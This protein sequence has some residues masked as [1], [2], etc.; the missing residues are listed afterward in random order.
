[1]AWARCTASPRLCA[2]SFR[3]GRDRSE[4]PLRE[5]IGNEQVPSAFNRL[6]PAGPTVSEYSSLATEIPA[7]VVICPSATA[8]SAPNLLARGALEARR[9]LERTG[10]WPY[11]Y[12][13]TRSSWIRE[14]ML[15]LVKTLLR[16][17][18]A[19]RADVEA[20]AALDRGDMAPTAGR[21]ACQRQLHT[22]VVICPRL[23]IGSSEAP[24]MRLCRRSRRILRREEEQCDWL[25]ATQS[26]ANWISSFGLCAGVRA[27][28][29]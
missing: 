22:F 3:Y 14:V 20:V 17:Y 13:K 2:P 21:P 1:M 24:S 23:L 4:H 8:Q 11:R 28:H 6:G 29:W 26:A 18:L 16:W 27:V 9:G 5:R 10:E 12:V 15:S 25:I 19:V 7:S